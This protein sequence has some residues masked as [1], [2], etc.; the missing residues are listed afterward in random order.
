VRVRPAVY[1]LVA[2]SLVAGVGMGRAPGGGTDPPRCEP[3]GPPVVFDGKV[4]DADAK[5]YL[6]LPFAVVDGTTRVEVGYR[7]RPDDDDTTLDLGLWDEDGAGTPAGFRG[8]SGSRHGYLG[9]EAEG[10]GPIFVQA[11]AADRGYRPGTV[12]PGVWNVDLG[13]A[14]VDADGARWKVQVRCLDVDVG[15]E[16]E[17][18]PVDRDHVARDE[19]GWYEGD[20]HLHG[21]HSN[22]D[23]PEGP[24]FIE[25][26][27]DAGLDFVPVTDY[28][29]DQHWY[30]LGEVQ[31]ENPD[32][33]IWPGREVIT[34]FGHAIVLGETPSTVEYR[35]GFDDVTLADI[36][37]DAV[38]DGALFQIAHPTIF[39]GAA[40]ESFCRGCEFE[41][42]DEIDWELV[43]SIEVVTGPVLVASD[44]GRAEPGEGGFANPFVPT[45]IDFWEERLLAGYKITAVSGSDDKLG[46]DFG[47]TTT[48]VYAEEL[49]RAGL[50]AAIRAG[51]A[52][53][54]ARGVDGSPALEL[55]ARTPDGQEGIVGDTL[56]GDTAEVTVT[57]R[58][59]SGQTLGIVANGREV[60]EV[61]VTSDP[62]THT[63]TA[64]R[65]AREGPLGTFWRVE[66]ADAE[67]LTTISNPI[68]L[69]DEPYEA[70]SRPEPAALDL[71]VDADGDGSGG[72]TNPWPWIALGAAVAV[73]AG[74]GAYWLLNRNR[75]T[76]PSAG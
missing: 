62:F 57:V 23:A 15:D 36:Q 5:T 34:Y 45:A 2:T 76:A 75:G 3:G 8:W 29:T 32:L 12:E 44:F 43:D 64:T 65:R 40:F 51:H 21:Y 22:P 20:M 70:P 50:T 47:M 28:V 38:A 68:F 66:T 1:A 53:V 18:D 37:A 25:F 41:L 58:D 67:S 17:P 39:P 49:S 4:T 48:S 61:P 6:L 14:S 46:P 9:E 42:S 30:E 13:I 26:A 27:R 24:E 35:H 31:R 63:F 73:I 69:A 11:D 10:T 52:Y 16:P 72:D 54:R 55:E 33:V 7:W 74:G 71:E 19:P 56:V 60:E 59:G